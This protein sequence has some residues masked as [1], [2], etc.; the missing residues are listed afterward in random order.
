M[1]VCPA[2]DQQFWRRGQPPIPIV[3]DYARGRARAINSIQSIGTITL[4]ST[5]HWFLLKGFT[6][7][8]L[9]LY[10]SESV[11]AAPDLQVYRMGLVIYHFLGHL[12]D[13]PSVVVLESAIYLCRKPRAQLSGQER[14]RWA[15]HL[16]TPRVAHRTQQQQGPAS[17][18]VHIQHEIFCSSHYMQ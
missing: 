15:K 11:V 6:L 7:S 10:S 3:D 9:E 12:I 17:S 4:F 8:F 13:R 2:A 14:P 16:G 18:R 1:K 5:I